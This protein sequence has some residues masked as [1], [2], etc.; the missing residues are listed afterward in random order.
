MNYQWIKDKLKQLNFRASLDSIDLRVQ[1]H[2]LLG[3]IKPSI[4]S[5]D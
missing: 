4:S 3:I 1:R 2:V 5:V